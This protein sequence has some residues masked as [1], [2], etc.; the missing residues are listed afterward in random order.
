M[1]A[2]IICVG[3]E[4]LQGN[5]VNTNAQY[6]SKKLSALGVEVCAQTVIGDE[7]GALKEGFLKAFNK[8]DLVVLTGGLGPTPDD[9]TKETISEALSLKLNLHEESLENIEKYFAKMG[10]I[11]M[12]ENN[13]KQAILPVGSIVMP[14]E[15]GT[16]PGVI[17]E[18]SRTIV[19]LFPGP[20]KELAKM[21][22][23]AA[24]PFL[25]Y[26]NSEII[27]SKSINIFGI[28]ESLVAEKLGKLLFCKNPVIAT[29]A[30]NSEVEVRITAKGKS[31]ET[32]HDLIEEK[33]DYIKELFGENVYGTNQPNIQNKVVSLLIKNDKKL[34]TAESCT[35]GLLSSMIT[36][37]PGASSVFDMGVTAYSNYIKIHALGVKEETLNKNGAVSADVAVE[38]AESVRKLTNSSIGIGITGVA[39][40]GRSENK[41]AGLVYVAVCDNEYN[42]VRELRL[43]GE[44]DKIRE[45]S[46]KYALDMARRYL[47]N[48]PMFMSFGTLKNEALKP[49]WDYSIPADDAVA[50]KSIE[51]IKIEPTGFKLTD[52]DIADLM[53]LT[54]DSYDYAFEDEQINKIDIQD[55]ETNHNFIAVTEDS[56]S[57]TPKKKERKKLNFKININ[58]NIKN[59]LPTKKDKLSEKIRKSVF[60]VALL[61]LIITLIVIAHY[62][63][64][65]AT[66]NKLIENTAKI[67]T[68]SD[69][70]QK[71]QSG[72][73]NGFE[74]L[75]KQNSDIKGWIKI[76]NTKINNPVYQTKNNDYY[77]NHNMN[78]QVSR[79]GAIF[80]DKD[81]KITEAGTSQN[82]VV[83]GHHMA[84][85]SMFGTLK[86][87]R[88]LNFYKD[89]P[90]IEFNSLY[91]KAQ[92]KV[93]AVII[94]NAD[95]KDD[96]GNIFSYR[97]NRFSSNTAFLDYV[98]ELKKRSIIDANVDIN[99][100]DKLLTLSTCIYDF[101]N[102]RLVVVA[103]KV[104]DGES[105]IL[106]TEAAK[107][108]PNP[109][110]PAAYY[111]KKGHTLSSVQ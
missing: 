64:S 55:N 78:K 50:I 51:D 49:V 110:Y 85:G 19:M 88:N 17:I 34:S 71:N 6:L 45:A 4:L 57:E 15:I 96:N 74:D 29:Y 18:K 86:K 61:T 46:A 42:F 62:F 32:V 53:I 79:Y 35:A 72:I 84:D 16:A 103:R 99:P 23:T 43:K 105:N 76:S 47:E 73:I 82:L 106:N 58:I 81:A 31:M 2:E 93:F 24:E 75:L 39:G 52:K 33:A 22:E 66:Q 41:P 3:T 20:P 68:A 10:K 44:R 80:L 30:K 12:P 108:N 90:I 36:D 91:E 67:W 70:L 21:F 14:N 9:L 7:K 65:G 13:K 102:A 54:D 26:K 1:R 111:E 59:F 60:L 89:N 63:I 95:P 77:V 48:C 94:T 40:P 5:I 109:L 104:R 101:D 83:Y 56:E 27:K 37:I 97:Y 98:E 107:Y 38:M 87:F 92:Y 11:K 28:G 69:S 25:R 100:N 8:Y